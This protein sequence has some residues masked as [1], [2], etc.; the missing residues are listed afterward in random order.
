MWE[1]LDAL[2]WWYVPV[3]ILGGLAVLAIVD[4]VTTRRRRR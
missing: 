4:A 2:P 1:Y 3:V